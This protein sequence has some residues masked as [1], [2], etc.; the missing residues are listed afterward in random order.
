MRSWAAPDFPHRA[1]SE[2]GNGLSAS[3]HPAPGQLQSLRVLR[4]LNAR[5]ALLPHDAFAG[6]QESANYIPAIELERADHSDRHT[7]A[8]F[9]L[10][11]TALAAATGFIAKRILK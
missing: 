10:T 11:G 8:L 3:L 6:Q 1:T 2:S 4:A 9:Y 7:Q 5:Q